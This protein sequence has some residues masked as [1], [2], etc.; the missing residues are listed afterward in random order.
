ME[1]LKLS[2][3]KFY[4]QYGD[5]IRQYEVFL[6]QMIH[7]ILGHDHIHSDTFHWSDIW[8]PC[9]LVIEL[10][11]INDFDLITEFQEVSIEHLQR[12]QHANR[13]HLLL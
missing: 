9:Y 1:C 11:L 5:L 6:S 2:L 7:D 12:V 10:D 4:G 13:E 8:L 3:I